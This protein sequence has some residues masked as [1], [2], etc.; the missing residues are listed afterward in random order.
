MEGREF[1]EHAYSTLLRRQVDEGGLHS[2]L[3]QLNSGVK[4]IDLVLALAGSP[5]GRLCN[6]EL[7]GLEQLKMDSR[8]RPRSR[9]VRRFF[10][11]QDW[12]ASN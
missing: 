9:L 12:Y 10:N 1:V 5:E 6:V 3:E 8:R 7:P 4:K 2:Y 11:V